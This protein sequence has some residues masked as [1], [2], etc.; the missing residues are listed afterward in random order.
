MK[1]ANFDNKEEMDTA[2]AATGAKFILY[3]NSKAHIHRANGCRT[4]WQNRTTRGNFGVYSIYQS[5]EDAE[6]AAYKTGKNVK[7]CGH[8]FKDS[9]TASREKHS[10]IKHS[11][12]DKE[13]KVENIP[14]KLIAIGKEYLKKDISE[15]PP[16]TE[17]KA[18][19][20][21]LCNLRE[22]PH[23]FVLGCLAD[24]QIP[25]ERAWQIPYIVCSELNAFS[26][27]E[28]LDHTETDFVR[29]F[30]ERHLHRFND[31]VAAHFYDALHKIHVEYADNAANI[32]ENTPCAATV[33]SRFRDFDGA[34]QKISTMAVNILY[35][36]F[37]VPFTD[38]GGIDISPDVHVRRV[39]RRMGIVPGG[40]PDDQTNKLVIK[41]ARQICPEYPGILDIGCWEI[42]KKYCHPVA[43]AA[44][45]CEH[46]LLKAEC[47]KLVQF[48]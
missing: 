24:F 9:V 11:L 45:D 42:G 6:K 16:L 15:L 14:M 25:A 32:W 44:P 18:A 21:R 8:C 17:N 31:K 40:L 46:C 35:R 2:I 47:K 22:F 27:S 26:L 19:N 41:V 1:T 10:N 29:V 7:L 13:V 28:L 12:S 4:L 37:K 23:V 36:R 33:V 38:L 34:G 48:D 3:V 30:R 43:E 39:F 5:Y 20:D